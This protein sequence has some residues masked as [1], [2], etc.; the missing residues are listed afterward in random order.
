MSLRCAISQIL[1]LIY[2]KLRRH[3]ALNTPN[4]AV[5]YHDY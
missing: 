4:S 3:V 2:Q 1:P 5:I